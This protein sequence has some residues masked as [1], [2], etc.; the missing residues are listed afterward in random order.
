[1]RQ[2]PE[3]ESVENIRP[4]A[5]AGIQQAHLQSFL[6]AGTNDKAPWHHSLSHY[7]QNISWHRT[8]KE[9]SAHKITLQPSAHASTF[10]YLQVRSFVTEPRT[11]VLGTHKFMLFAPQYHIPKSCTHA[12]S[13]DYFCA[14]TWQSIYVRCHPMQSWSD[15]N[16]TISLLQNRL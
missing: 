11:W 9:A 8:D 7:K 14:R 4:P 6:D 10:A 12:C 3:S 1:M 2:N 16:L 13:A 15:L 5:P